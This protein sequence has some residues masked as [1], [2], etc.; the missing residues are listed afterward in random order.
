MTGFVVVSIDTQPCSDD[1]IDACNSRL[2]DQVEEDQYAQEARARANAKHNP[3]WLFLVN[4]HSTVVVFACYLI[5]VSYSS[6]VIALERSI[7]NVAFSLAV[8]L[9]SLVSIA[10]SVTATLYV[11]QTASPDFNGSTIDWVLLSFAVITPISASISMAFNRRDLALR[12][13]A[14]LRATALELYMSQACWDWG[15]QSDG[16]GNNLSTGRSRS[17]VDWLAHSD[18]MLSVILNLFCEMTRYLT[19]PT[20]SRARHKVTGSGQCEADE[21]LSISADLYEKIMERFHTITKLCEEL[22]VYGLPPN[23]ATRVRRKWTLRGALLDANWC[24][25]VVA[26]DFFSQTGKGCYWKKLKICE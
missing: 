16:K 8:Q 13:I 20:S 25:R 11:H 10:L 3:G 23:E 4:A 19:L 12:S 7:T 18:K 14:N 24:H 15:F 22:K 26:N 6:A 1:S 5:S 21:L 17:S 2:D 9:E